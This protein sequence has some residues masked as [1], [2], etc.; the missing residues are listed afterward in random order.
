MA[1]LENTIEKVIKN[2]K[3]VFQKMSLC[4]CVVLN[5]MFVSNKRQTAET[6]LSRFL[7]EKSDDLQGRSKI[8]N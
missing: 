7:C 6:S 5:D 4:M 3:Y 8:G 1:S 2:H